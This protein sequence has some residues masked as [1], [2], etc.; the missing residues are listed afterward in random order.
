MY[1]PAGPDSRKPSIFNKVDS[2]PDLKHDKGHN[3]DG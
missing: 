3:Y 2:L 1:I